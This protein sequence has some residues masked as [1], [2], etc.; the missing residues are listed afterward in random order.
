[1]AGVEQTKK[2]SCPAISLSMSSGSSL[3]S[4]FQS[5]GCPFAAS[6]KY[7]YG[8]HIA[9]FTLAFCR[10]I[11]L[12]QKRLPVQSSKDRLCRSA[13]TLDFVKGH[14]YEPDCKLLLPTLA[15]VTSR[16]IVFSE[17]CIGMHVLC[18]SAS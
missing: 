16:S 3:A 1:M 4:K 14:V 18:F 13:S 9:A 12:C 6:S 11:A 7:F 5:Q 17:N 8:A 15:L 10:G 2:C